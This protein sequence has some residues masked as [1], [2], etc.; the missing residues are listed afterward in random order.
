MAQRVLSSGATM[1]ALAN[2]P[3]WKTT[4]ACYALVF[5][6][7]AAFLRISWLWILVM[8][9]VY[10]A[11]HWF[12][13]TITLSDQSWPDDWRRTSANVLL[14]MVPELIFL[15]SIAVVWHRLILRA[16]TPQSMAYLSVDQTV[17]A[18]AV[19][20][21]VVFIVPLLLALSPIVIMSAWF[22]DASETEP[23]GETDAQQ[24]SAAILF[25]LLMSV[26]VPAGII[27]MMLPLRFCLKFPAIA[28]SHPMTLL[29]S[30]QLTR[31][32]TWRLAFAA[33]LCSLPIWFLLWM[34]FVLFF[35]EKAAPLTMPAYIAQET[36][37]SF[38]YAIPTIFGVTLFSLAYRHF[39]DQA[40]PSTP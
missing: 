19:V 14:P 40:P 36:L 5:A 15:A 12:L 26:V 23:P 39:V 2:L 35:E 4:R 10:A 11:V 18:Y 9:P 1:S 7:L 29:D 38:A 13:W 20:G 8:I 6:N 22:P 34:W 28:L 32:N 30:W 25:P 3:V 21:F 17:R 37:F 33:F 16:Q 24:S 27:A 31:G